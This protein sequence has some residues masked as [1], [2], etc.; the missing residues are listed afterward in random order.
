[1]SAVSGDGDGF[2]PKQNYELVGV[3]SWGA[4]CADADYPGVYT[5]VSRQLDWIAEVTTQGWSTCPRE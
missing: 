3:V 5:R 2:S 1:M 4:G